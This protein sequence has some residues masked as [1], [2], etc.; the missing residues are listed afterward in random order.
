ML[1]SWPILSIVTFLPLMGV[2][3]ILLASGN[4][5]SSEHNCKM[6]TYLIVKCYITLIYTVLLD[7][8]WDCSK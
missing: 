8:G 1:S 6:L 5:K 3:F 2:L 4:N 7:G